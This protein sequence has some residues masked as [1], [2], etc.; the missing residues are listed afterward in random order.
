MTHHQRPYDQLAVSRVYLQTV[1][2]D[3]PHLEQVA[4]SLIQQALDERF[5]GQGLRAFALGIGEPVELVAE[6]APTTYRHVTSV[7]D[8]LI[9]RLMHGSAINYNPTRQVPLRLGG[10]AVVRLIAGPSVDDL[11][12]MI[13]HLAPLLLEAFQDALAAYWSAKPLQDPLSTRWRI[14]SNQMRLCLS[15]A[16]QN[17]PLASLEEKQVLSEL[18]PLKADRDKAVGAGRFRVSLVYAV[19][20]GDVGEWLPLLVL[21]RQWASRR[22][23]YVYSPGQSVLALDTLDDLGPLLPRYLSRH[24][25]GQAIQWTLHEP[26]GDVFDQLALCIL[27]KQLRDLTAVRW[28]TFPSVAYYKRLLS[29]L[30]APHAWFGAPTSLAEEALPLWLQTAAAA[31]R[32][33]YSQQLD[34]LAGV[35]LEAA[36]ADYLQGLDPI[37]AY[38]R[39]ALQ[40]QMA[41]DYPQEVVIDPDH[42]AL[43]F[44]RTQGGTVGWTQT[45]QRT[46]TQ[47]A[48]D[49]PFVQPYARVELINLAEPG[50]APDWWLKVPYLQA[51]IERVDIG[52]QYPAMLERKLLGDDVEAARR[53][54][55]FCAQVRVQLPLLALEHVIRRQHGFTDE[56]LALVRQAV[57][58]DPGAGQVN[59]QKIVVRPLAFLTHAGGKAHVARNM[60]VIG[61]SDVA[62]SVHV[63]YRPG[64]PQLLEQFPTRQA[65]LD[66]VART[67][68]ALNR[69]VLDSLDEPARALFGNGGFLSPHEQRFLQGDEYGPSRASSPALLSD[70]PVAGDFLLRVFQDNAQALVAQAKR[71]AVSTEA[72]RWRAFEN[73]LWQLF[74]VVLPLLRG[75]LSAAGWLLQM[76]QGSQVLVALQRNG[77]QATRARATAQFISTLSALLLHPVAS[78]DQRLRLPQGHPV[79]VPA[80]L[81]QVGDQL[82]TKAAPQD[83]CPLYTPSWGSATQALAPAMQAELETFKWRAQNAHPSQP[84]PAKPEFAQT[85]GATKGLYRVFIGPQ[86]FHLHAYLEGGLYPV[87]DVQEGTRVVDLAQPSR[88]GPWIKSDGQGNWSFDFGLRLR[89]G[90]PRKKNMPTRA[91]FQRRNLELAQQHADAVAQMLKVEE[92]L[93][94]VL[95]LYQRMHVS[96][97][98]SFTDA[99]RQTVQQRYHEQLQEQARAQLHRIEVFKQK[100]ENQPIARF[101]SSLI[102]HIEDYVDN[103]RRQMALL[104]LSRSAAKP[105][106]ATA[107]RWYKELE[108]EDDDVADQA[109]RESVASLSLMAGF[110]E[111]LLQLSIEERARLEE[112]AAI[113][114]YEPATSRL[115]D[116][117]G[118]HRTPLDWRIKLIE[119]Y[120]GMALKRRPLPQEY[121]DFLAAKASL[122][123]L[124]REVLSHKNLLETD[125]LTLERRIELLGDVLEQYSGIQDRLG[126]IFATYPQLFEAQY[127]DKL[128]ALITDLLSE[129]EHSQALMLRE[130]TS[131]VVPQV[132]RVSASGTRQRLIVTRNR[133]VLSGRVRERTPDSDVEIVEVQDPIDQH[134]LG[135]FKE[136]AQAGEWEEIPSTT[137]RPAAP[138]RALKHLLGDADTLLGRVDRA[139]SDARKIARQSNSPIG[140]E[141]ELTRVGEGLRD[142]ARKI[143]QTLE[144]REQGG[145]AAASKR[146]ADLLSN[147]EAAALRLIEEGRQ[148]R[149]EII[150]RNPPQAPRIEYLK[151][152]GEVEIVKVEGWVKLSR[153]D[154]YL[155]EYLIRDR[156]RRPVA[157]AHF[158][159]RSPQAPAA[160]FTAAHLKLPQQRYLSF[161]PVEGQSEQI[162]LAAYRSTIGSRLAQSLFFA[163]SQ[164]T[165]RKGRPDYW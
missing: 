93:A 28:S 66:S 107:E 134:S 143:S 139:I 127:G 130:R 114:G 157:Y 110:N 97:R 99:H 45:T 111:Q 55:L 12:Q 158:H 136:S 129:A 3:R 54:G 26:D 81:E 106:P 10:G 9:G 119:V 150:L 80:A 53:R 17:P 27:E 1:F 5:A 68:T 164:T 103:L 2:A 152:Q 51:L 128:L 161:V 29:S 146:E 160:E 151:A 42:Y 147:L 91:D 144:Q 39:K 48:L 142:S 33:R 140:V 115:R 46:L 69:A 79:S 60:F 59:G 108:S 14:V 31:T 20:G 15:Q 65:V 113:A 57:A 49:N 41:L 138:A 72:Q 83:I 148:L 13:N 87:R 95:A 19:S 21:Q 43:A 100:N 165:T 52:K 145:G 40:A 73:D 141:A 131:Q 156:E 116:T 132:A 94:A 56:G 8:A 120:Q 82:L 118:P 90:M 67:G 84:W 47:W 105:S 102:E 149:I 137:L 86:R 76:M 44:T 124:V 154:D 112:L 74:D 98:G 62:T 64:G 22:A 123:L 101:E 109:H 36:G 6:G 71:Q 162:T 63:L 16:P 122:D 78:L 70:E 135:T 23:T 125:A 96:E 34:D 88:L 77:D 4:N 163:V 85:E 35:Q 104:I 25:S 117:A 126:F 11:E 58:V 155:Q 18:Y 159:Y 89:G 38:T 133:Q 61:A 153:E 92:K 50:Y 7:A 32:L 121:G 75:P 24:R 37:L 30:T